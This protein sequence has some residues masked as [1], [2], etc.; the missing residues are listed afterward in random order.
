VLSRVFPVQWFAKSPHIS[1]DKSKLFWGARQ[2][3]RPI[4]SGFLHFTQDPTATL[5]ELAFLGFW[6]THLLDQL[7]ENGA[8][9]PPEIWNQVCFA[10]AM[11]KVH[12]HK[13]NIYILYKMYAHI[14]FINI[15]KLHIWKSDSTWNP[16]SYCWRVA[17]APASSGCSL[18]P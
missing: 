17:T 10:F 16:P 13:N 14:E 2:K 6:N 5:N 18:W 1:P 9:L 7:F 11:Y 12:I 3:D 8:L 15:W 4:I